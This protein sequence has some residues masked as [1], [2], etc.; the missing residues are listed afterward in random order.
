MR[1]KFLIM[2]KAKNTSDKKQIYTN[3]IFQNKIQRF[4]QC[5]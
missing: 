2:I 1:I 5:P 4:A 3:Q